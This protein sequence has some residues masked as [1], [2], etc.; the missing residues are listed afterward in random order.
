MVFATKA[1]NADGY[2]EYHEHSR[3]KPAMRNMLRLRN[4]LPK[5]EIDVTANS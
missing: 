5:I 4:M 1:T 3:L 2:G